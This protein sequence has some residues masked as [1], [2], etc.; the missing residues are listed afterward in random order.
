[1]SILKNILRKILYYLLS[2]DYRF[3]RR[4]ANCSIGRECL[5]NSSSMIEF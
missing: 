3:A 1:M 4:G 2:E 5:I